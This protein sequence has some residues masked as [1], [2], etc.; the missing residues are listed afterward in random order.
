MEVDVDNWVKAVE[1]YGGL[2]YVYA[3]KARRLRALAKKMGKRCLW[4]VNLKVPLYR[5]G[6]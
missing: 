6:A 5:A 4:G 3:G 2:F 1:E